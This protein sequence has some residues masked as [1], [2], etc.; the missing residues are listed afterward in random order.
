MNTSFSRVRFLVAAT[1]LFLAAQRPSLAGSAT[2]SSNPTS[3][4]WNITANWRPQ[5]V[6][7][8]I[9]DIATFDASNITDVLVDFGSNISLDSAVFDSGAP[10]YSITLDVSNLKLYGAGI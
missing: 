2:W 5:T 9:T 7:N 6:P 10:A 3:E 8:S 4:D 1:L